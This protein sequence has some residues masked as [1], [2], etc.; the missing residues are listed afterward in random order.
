MSIEIGVGGKFRYTRDGNRGVLCDFAFGLPRVHFLFPHFSF[1]SLF[2]MVGGGRPAVS[3][4]G[5][6]AGFPRPAVAWR[7]P[8]PS[9]NGADLGCA[10]SR[11]AYVRGDAARVMFEAV[12]FETAGG[13]I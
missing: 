11:Q 2:S 10:V 7:A 3:C 4:F 1:T 6:Y 12:V 8:A 13:H 5:V 9:D